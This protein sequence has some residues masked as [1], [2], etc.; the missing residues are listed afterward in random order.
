MEGQSKGS[1]NVME[2]TSHESKGREAK[3]G[4]CD[5]LLRVLALVLTLVAA[6]V[7]GA[8][9]QTTIVPIKFLDSLPPLDVPVTAKWHYLSAFVYFVVANIIACAY[10][11]V[12]VVVVVA[13]RSERVWMSVVDGLMVGLLFSSNGAAIAVGVLGL[14]GN[15]HIHWNKVCNVFG[16]FCDQMAASLLISLLGSIAF[17]LLLLL[18][19]FRLHQTN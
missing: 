1:L 12:S 15:S 17:L 14:Q 9:K 3:Y 8:D 18:P 4:N 16:K 10:A 5:L 6:V 13:N 2:G 11:S 7:S 19:L